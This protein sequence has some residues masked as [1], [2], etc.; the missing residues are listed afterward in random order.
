M[1]QVIN[2]ELMLGIGMTSSLIPKEF[3]WIN[4]NTENIKRI[5]ND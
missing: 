3:F 4:D 5:N 1:F 2:V